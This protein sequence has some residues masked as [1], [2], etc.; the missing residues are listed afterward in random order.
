MYQ[1]AISRVPIRYWRCNVWSMIF[2]TCTNF[3][4]N[5]IHK[6]LIPDWSVTCT[7]SQ[8]ILTYWP[9]SQSSV[10]WHISCHWSSGGWES[11][12]IKVKVLV[13]VSAEHWL[14][15]GDMSVICQRSNYRLLTDS[16]PIHFN[17][18]Q[19]YWLSP[20][21]D[22]TETQPIL[23]QCS[24]DKTTH[25]IMSTNSWPRCRP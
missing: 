7:K 22:V 15:V 24:T 13:K 5:L 1:W 23:D 25:N 10:G 9:T 19:Y 21:Q 3:F 20:V 14:S 12:K 2:I 16:Q 6:A 11:V 4:S 8:E 17:G 18:Q